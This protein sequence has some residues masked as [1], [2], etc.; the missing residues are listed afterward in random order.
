MFAA[1]AQVYRKAVW[2]ANLLALSNTL[3]KF[4]TFVIH[5]DPPDQRHFKFVN[6]S[7]LLPTY[8]YSG[9][10]YFRSYRLSN[11]LQADYNK[12]ISYNLNV[13]D[14]FKTKHGEENYV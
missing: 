9:I 10:S 2:V 11:A 4:G 3:A 5:P 8:I 7:C 12:N 6:G 13:H 14:T 1:L